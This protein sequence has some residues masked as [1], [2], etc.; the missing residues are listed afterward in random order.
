MVWNH[1]SGRYVF[2]LLPPGMYITN[3]LFMI[4]GDRNLLR[5][6]MGILNSR[7]ADTLLL[8]FTGLSTLGKY[9][10]GAKSQ[11]QK[12]PIPPYDPNDPTHRRLVETVDEIL[13][14]VYSSDYDPHNP[15]DGVKRLEEEIDSLVPR[16]YGIEPEEWENLRALP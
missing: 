1:V 8:L 4:T 16:L 10:Y 9:A 15:P 3:A 5:Y 7:F 14:E 13:K 6:L 11:I 12:I 2:A